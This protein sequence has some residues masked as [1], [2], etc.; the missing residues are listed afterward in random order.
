VL[1]APPNPQSYERG[2]WGPAEALELPGG[3]GWWLPDGS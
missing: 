3:T 1:D 2:S